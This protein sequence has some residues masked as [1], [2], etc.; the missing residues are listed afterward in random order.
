ML[1]HGFV[2]LRHYGL[3]ASGNVNTK[4]ARA[5]E[6]LERQ[7]RPAAGSA[8]PAS[9]TRKPKDKEPWWQTLLRHTGVDVRAC[10]HCKTGR[11]VRVEVIPS[12]FARPMLARS[13]PR[14]S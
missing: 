2:R 5:R 13:P 10:P 7:A 6:I 8:Q 1:P 4:L 9:Q 11:M 14:A 3:L 12:P